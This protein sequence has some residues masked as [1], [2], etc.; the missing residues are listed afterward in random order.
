VSGGAKILVVDDEKAIRRF[1]EAGLEAQGYQFFEAKTGKEG[2]VS[3]RDNRP[4]LLVLDLCL[5]DMSG[6]DVLKVV[7]EISSVPVIV[8]T[9]QSGDKDKESLLDSGADDYLTKPFSLPELLA[10]IRVALRHGMNLKNSLEFSNGP[11]TVDFDTRRVRVDGRE[12]ELTATE[13]DLL[14]ILIKHAGKIV[15][16]TQLLKEVWG[17]AAT[18][19]SHY[20][21]IY[22]GQLRRK[23][24]TVPELK[25]FIATEQGVGYRMAVLREI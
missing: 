15:T 23:L 20:L 21:R 19:R 16:Q 24:E 14:K 4:D 3:A 17:P 18:E 5:P 6:L 13:F 1:L 9:V 12:V 7:R 25:G 2:I 10:R 22:I 8:L 11:L